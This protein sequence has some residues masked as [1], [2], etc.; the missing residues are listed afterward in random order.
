MA[1][2]KRPMRVGYLCWLLYCIIFYRALVKVVELYVDGRM[3]QGD[4][5]ALSKGG[6][7][8]KVH[9]KESVQ[10]I[11]S[12]AVIESRL[13]SIPSTQ[14]AD[15]VA[16]GSLQRSSEVFLSDGRHQKMV[17]RSQKLRIFSCFVSQVD[18]VAIQEWPGCIQVHS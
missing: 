2:I 13:L 6:W 9:E 8:F 7:S 14:G 1:D 4:A 16:D 17:I 5:S 18:V 10:A 15:C 12:A 3:M 11:A